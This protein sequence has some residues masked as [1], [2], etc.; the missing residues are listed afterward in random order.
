[1]TAWAMM[2]TALRENRETIAIAIDD[3]IIDDTRN[4][5]FS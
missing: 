2:R 4:A 3:G 1:M 5:D